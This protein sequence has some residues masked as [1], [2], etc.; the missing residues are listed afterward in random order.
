MISMSKDIQ[1]NNHSDDFNAFDAFAN[2]A[3]EDSGERT[4]FAESVINREVHAKGVSD[5]LGAGYS[6]LKHLGDSQKMMLD[7][8]A[9]QF[10]QVSSPMRYLLKDF[11]KAI[12]R[13]EVFKLYIGD[14]NHQLD[15]KQH[16]EAL[17][18]MHPNARTKI[19]KE[20]Q[21]KLSSGKYTPYADGQIKVKYHTRIE[22]KNGGPG[23]VDVDGEVTLS[24]DTLKRH[25]DDISLSQDNLRTKINETAK[26]I[27]ERNVAKGTVKKDANG[28]PFIWTGAKWLAGISAAL[29]VMN[30]KD[31][32]PA[33]VQGMFRPNTEVQLNDSGG[34]SGPVQK[35]VDINATHSSSDYHTESGATYNPGSTSPGVNAPGS[36]PSKWDKLRSKPINPGFRNEEVD[37]DWWSSPSGAKK[38]DDMGYVGSADEN[39]VRIAKQQSEAFDE[40]SDDHFAKSIADQVIASE[41]LLAYYGFGDNSQPAEKIIPALLLG[42]FDNMSLQEYQKTHTPEE[43]KRAM[44]RFKQGLIMFNKELGT[45]SNK[46]ENIYNECQRR[47]ES[48]PVGSPSDAPKQ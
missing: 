3:S 10:S 30:N 35:P 6:W 17:F 32:I 9:R 31:D 26:S 11:D 27:S 29:W 34:V 44:L 23:G 7:E 24:T 40:M 1:K 20:I 28:R 8:Y 2:L 12:K 43:T 36:A 15:S 33:A 16:Y 14:I 41:N 18:Q 25:V 4:S 22:P 47:F 13:P 38:Y 48:K 39:M 19:I 45:M 21:E 37:N 46:L 42:N 5:L